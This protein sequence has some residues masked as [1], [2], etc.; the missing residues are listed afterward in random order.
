MNE[1]TLALILTLGLVAACKPAV[2][3]AAPSPFEEDDPAA[4]DDSGPPGAALAGAAP[5]AGAAYAPDA[6]PGVA[7]AARDGKPRRF[8][9][10]M[11]VTRAALL[12]TLDTGPGA[13][14]RGVELKPRLHGERFTGWEIVQFMPGETRFDDFDLRPGDIVGPINGHQ[15]ARPEHLAT[16]W[17]EL[18]TADAV[19]IQVQRGANSFTLRFEIADE[20]KSPVP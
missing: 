20:V 13:F 5:A 2:R 6:T 7:P 14:L 1:L 19:V 4:L 17:A 16:L 8:L 11:T 12:A 10:R 18:R 9:R 3:V 15:V